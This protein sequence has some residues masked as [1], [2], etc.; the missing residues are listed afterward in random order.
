MQR[1][2]QAL[3]SLAA[4][5]AAKMPGLLHLPEA[6]FVRVHHPQGERTVYSVLRNRAHSNVAFLMGESLR[7][8]AEKDTLTVFPGIIG[9][10]PNFM[11]DVPAGDAE[12]FASA[13]RNA[14]QQQQFEQV[15]EQWGVRRTHPQFWD[16]LHDITAWHREHEPLQAGV[17][18]INR[19][20]NL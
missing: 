8:E 1:A 2:D 12:R 20:E 18:D 16:I 4:T 15:V 6:M 9:G 14:E 7:Y 5:P 13:L 3:A 11:F 17:F 19:F 10:Y